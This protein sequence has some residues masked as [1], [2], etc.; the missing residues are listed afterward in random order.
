MCIENRDDPR[1]NDFL[2]M[3]VDDDVEWRFLPAQKKKK[4]KEGK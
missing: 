4:K 2:A 3:S 1:Q